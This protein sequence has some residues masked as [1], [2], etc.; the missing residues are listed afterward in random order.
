M[1]KK[2]TWQVHFAMSFVDHLGPRQRL[3]YCLP[4]VANDEQ[5]RHGTHEPAFDL[6]LW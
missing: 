5:E 2:L 1:T 4:V 3:V 6:E